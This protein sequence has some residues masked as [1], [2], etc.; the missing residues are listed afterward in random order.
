[1]RRQT[2]AQAPTRRTVQTGAA[3]ALEARDPK[4]PKPRHRRE[5]GKMPAA[6]GQGRQAR[7]STHAS[8]AA[9]PVRRRERAESRATG[10]T[11]RMEGRARRSSRAG[12]A[13]KGH[14]GTPRQACHRTGGREWGQWRPQATAAPARPVR[15]PTQRADQ[16]R[17]ESRTRA[18]GRGSPRPRGRRGPSVTTATATQGWQPRAS[19]HARPPVQPARCRQRAKR[20]PNGPKRRRPSNGKWGRRH[21]P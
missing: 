7:T 16:A 21:S 4:P 3:Q 17:V 9:A 19:M 6:N 10:S 8:Q 13:P 12:R 1:M 2:P 14:T 18:R 5:P 15:A 11:R 20:R